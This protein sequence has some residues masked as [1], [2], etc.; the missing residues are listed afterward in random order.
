[1]PAPPPPAALPDASVAPVATAAIACLRDTDAIDVTLLEGD[2]NTI[3]AC[4]APTA[5]FAIDRRTSAISAWAP[6]RTPL[7]SLIHTHASITVE[8][9]RARYSRLCADAD[10][11]EIGDNLLRRLGRP[12]AGDFDPAHGMVAVFASEKPSDPP[13][14]VILPHESANRVKLK[15]PG[16][17]LCTDAI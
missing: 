1:V 11:I 12:V 5:C 2:A 6:P 8:S 3:H 15:H 7:R 17:D 4:F 13:T 16:T 14:I 10:C 9:A